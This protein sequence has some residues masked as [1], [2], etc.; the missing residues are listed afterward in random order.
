MKLRYLVVPAAL[1]ILMV[2]IVAAPALAAP[3]GPPNYGVMEP[4]GISDK[5]CP[6]PDEENDDPIH[7]DAQKC[8]PQNIPWSVT[9]HEG[10]TSSGVRIISDD[11]VGEALPAATGQVTFRCQSR[12]GLEYK[13]TAQGLEERTSYTVV[14]LQFGAG[15]VT[16]GTFTSDTRGNGILNGVLHLPKGGY[17]FMFSVVDG[18]GATVLVMDPIDPVVGIAVL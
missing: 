17:G 14:A 5:G 16:L 3:S 15:P 8:L 6:W 10:V 11:L 7:A 2:L 4:R 12:V 18:N 1:T 9:E 13:V